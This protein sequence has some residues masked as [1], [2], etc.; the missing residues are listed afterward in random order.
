MQVAPPLARACGR[1]R[2]GPPVFAVFFAVFACCA[3]LVV[4]LV[5]R[6]FRE[7]EDE[8]RG[9]GR[10]RPGRPRP[11]E[12]HPGARRVLLRCAGTGPGQ[13]EDVRAIAVDGAGRIYASDYN[14]TGRVQ[15]F[16]AAGTFL[17]QW[18]VSER[19][20]VSGMAATRDGTVLVVQ[21]G[22]IT[23]FDGASGRRLGKVAYARGFHD[24]CTRPDGSV[25]AYGWFSGHDRIVYFD[26]AG[27]VTREVSDTLRDQLHEVLL[28]GQVAMDGTGG[29]GSS[30]DS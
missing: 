28:D 11:L 4:W 22:E 14:R 29:P 3:A 5:T 8:V 9:K 1:G 13:F 21:E 16:A 19:Y 30:P 10:R 18:R 25:A 6:P 24:V 7:V 15:A 17:T 20:P 27:R 2:V 23:K 12:D 26:N